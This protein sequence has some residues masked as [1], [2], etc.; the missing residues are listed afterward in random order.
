MPATGLSVFDKIEET[1]YVGWPD[2]E[3]IRATGG[4]ERISISGDVLVD[5]KPVEGVTVSTH[6]LYEYG[7]D[8]YKTVS[9]KADSEGKFTLDGLLP[10]FEYRIQASTG[11]GSNTS[12][13]VQ[14]AENGI[15]VTDLK[16]QISTGYILKGKVSRYDGTPAKKAVVKVEGL[17]EIRTKDD[18][19]FEVTGMKTGASTI[20]FADKGCAPLK[21]KYDFNIEKASELLNITLKEEQVL[22]GRMI[23]K[24]SEPMAKKRII[25]F[26]TCFVGSQWQWCNTY[27]DSDGYFKLGNLGDEAY[28][29]WI[30]E[31]GNRAFRASDSP[32]L[33]RTVNGRFALDDKPGRL[34]A[35]KE[36]LAIIKNI[37]KQFID[38]F[39]DEMN[40]GNDGRRAYNNFEA[41]CQHLKDIDSSDLK[42]SKKAMASL[43]NLEAVQAV[44]KF[45]EIIQK[46]DNKDKVLLAIRGLGR[47]GHVP[48]IKTLIE[49]SKQADTVIAAYAKVAM[50]EIA[51]TSYGDESAWTDWL[52]EY[53]KNRK[54]LDTRGPDRL[55]ESFMKNISEGKVVI[56]SAAFLP[57]YKGQT[58][59]LREL[60]DQTQAKY[61]KLYE[62]IEWP[63]VNG[64]NC[65][66]MHDKI[67][68]QNWYCKFK[69]NI[70]IDGK[71]YKKG[72]SLVFTGVCR[73]YN[74]E[75]W[76]LELKLN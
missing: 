30:E 31:A 16:L 27:T 60:D 46:N 6:T 74:Q 34:V 73:E 20:K 41:I 42:V 45:V 9:G 56:A 13:T 52:K 19:T 61:K 50:C 63:K 37:D 24:N 1:H 28:G 21:L 68:E 70:E 4:K 11:T 71:Q 22:T 10:G 51:G 7:K 64:G 66:M 65:Y 55:L 69:E 53:E 58:Q 5:G 38:L 36:T 72:E 43:G 32:V 26:F 57:G 23:D 14:T 8:V 67:Q 15:D 12:A 17:S 39:L 33:I 47:I 25:G 76:I 44:E 48:T 35:N 18:G 49:I 29:I 75:W 2:F 62:A 59:I 54:K 3:T 40:Y